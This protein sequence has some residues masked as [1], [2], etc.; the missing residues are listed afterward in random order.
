MP[1]RFFQEDKD[2]NQ[3]E[4]KKHYSANQGRFI[5]FY[6]PNIE[7]TRSTVAE[8]L[9]AVALTSKNRPDRP[10]DQ[11]FPKLIIHLPSHPSWFSG[12]SDLIS[13]KERLSCLL[14]E[15]F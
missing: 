6:T 15:K 5:A 1:V 13:G 10:V 8:N 4:P 3:A 12:N 9:T 14:M 7:G 2:T 11:R